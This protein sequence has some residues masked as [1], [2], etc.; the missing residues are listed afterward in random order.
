MNLNAR[1][2]SVARFL[3]ALAFGL[4]P[5]S[6]RRCFGE[7]VWY[8]CSPRLPLLCQNVKSLGCGGRCGQPRRFRQCAQC[9][10]RFDVRQRIFWHHGCAVS[11]AH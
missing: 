4:P 3:F 9:G 6:R 8:H 11:G 10:G 2:L 1:F 7:C 5:T